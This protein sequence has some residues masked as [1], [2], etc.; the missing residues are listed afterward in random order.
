VVATAGFSEFV[1]PPPQKREV[2]ISSE[3]SENFTPSTKD[4]VFLKIP[5]PSPKPTNQYSGCSAAITSVPVFHKS[6]TMELSSVHCRYYYT[7]YSPYLKV[8]WL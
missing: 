1:T 4:K 6:E 7:F 8:F 5:H 3:S 2:T